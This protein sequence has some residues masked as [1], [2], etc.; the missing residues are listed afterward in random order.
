MSEAKATKT[1]IK[2][3]TNDTDSLPA[4]LVGQSWGVA[5]RAAIQYFALLREVRGEVSQRVLATLDF[6]ESLQHA[7]FKLARETA[8]RVDKVA[9]DGVD[10]SEQMTLA[11]LGT[12]RSTALGATQLAA[13]PLVEKAA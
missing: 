7:V 2:P 5:E 11:V 13:A 12:T 6:L 3:L 1:D 10:A 4:T 8:T 9:G